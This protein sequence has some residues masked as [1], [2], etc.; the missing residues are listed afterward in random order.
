MTYSETSLA[1]HRL[2]CSHE[3]LADAQLLLKSGSASGAVAMA[4]KAAKEA[5]EAA[6]LAAGAQAVRGESIL[7]LVAQFVRDGRLSP[8]SFNAL[9]TMMDM[10]H[11]FNE[12]D[13]AAANRPE[14]AAAIE[15]LKAFIREMG[16]M[17]SQ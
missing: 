10:C 8:A 13:M 1:K 15:N 3:A 7:F 6:L 16:S 2:Q 14:A 5:A 9:R 11:M 4:L 12:R 17:V